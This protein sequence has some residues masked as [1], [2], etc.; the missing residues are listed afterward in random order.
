MACAIDFTAPIARRFPVE[1]PVVF[2]AAAKKLAAGGGAP[3][4]AFLDEKCQAPL[5]DPK[6]V[7]AALKEAGAMPTDDDLAKMS[8][9]EG[10]KVTRADYIGMMVELA[11]T[12]A[13]LQESDCKLLGGTVEGDVAVLQVQAK[14][15]G[16]VGRTD[17]IMAKEG[18]TW[19]VRREGTWAPLP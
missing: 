19:K 8:K 4:K 11:K 15:M 3:G 14:T 7:E 6:S 1:K 5:T 2:T 17:V 9:S 18:T 13:P 12:M 16:S 10:H